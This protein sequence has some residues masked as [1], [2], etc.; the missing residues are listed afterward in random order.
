MRKITA[1]K[2][3]RRWLSFWKGTGQA[4]FESSSSPQDRRYSVPGTDLI[5]VRNTCSRAYQKRLDFSPI[6]Q[7]GDDYDCEGDPAL[8]FQQLAW[9]IGRFVSPDMV[10]FSKNVFTPYDN[11][12]RTEPLELTPPQ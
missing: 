1:L 11:F 6:C 3:P 10:F 5:A 12:V 9:L 2:R 8:L 7:H 4:G